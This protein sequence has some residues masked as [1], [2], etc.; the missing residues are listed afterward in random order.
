MADLGKSTIIK[1]IALIN[2]IVLYV[3]LILFHSYIPT[4]YERLLICAIF[5]GFMVLYIAL[6]LGIIIGKPVDKDLIGVW[7][8][9]AT[10]AYFACGVILIVRFHHSN[11]EMGLVDGILSLLMA[12]ITF[13][14][15][16]FTIKN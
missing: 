2:A 16:Y 3:L 12:V 7:T 4:A 6:V 11:H 14:D 10:C 15:C 8:F 9:Y 13:L 1:L 5:A